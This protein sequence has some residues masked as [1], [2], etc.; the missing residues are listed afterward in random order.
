M[1]MRYMDTKYATIT[2][3][4]SNDSVKKSDAV[5]WLEGDGLTRMNEVI[6]VF[7]QGLAE[8]IVI[9]GGFDS[10]PI[11]IPAPKLAEKLYKKNIPKDKVIIEGI[12]Q[13][14]FEQGTEVM[15]LVKKNNWKKII[16]VA[17]HYHQLRAFLTFLKTMENAN[18]K[19]Q[20]YNSPARNISWFEKVVNKNR[21]ELFEGELEKIE[22]YS[23]KGH[24]ASVEDAIEYEQEKELQS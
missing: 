10:E 8:N 15:K 11:G 4:V 22:E 16:L 24:V 23:K 5:I 12:S 18:L 7:E 1:T 9:S 6:R 21:K 2:A 20:I 3:I 17:S 14:T 13:N 19:I